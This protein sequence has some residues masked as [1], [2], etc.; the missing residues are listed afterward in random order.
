MFYLI[1]RGVKVKDKRAE[2]QCERNANLL[3]RLFPVQAANKGQ[4]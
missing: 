3:N 4:G 2:Q 1:L